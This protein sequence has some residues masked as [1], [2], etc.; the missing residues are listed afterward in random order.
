MDYNE[1]AEF[2]AM[3]ADEMEAMDD[4]QSQTAKPQSHTDK[5]Q[6][7]TKSHTPHNKE[8]C[9]PLKTGLK[10]QNEFTTGLSTNTTNATNATDGVSDNTQTDSVGP[11][12][13]FSFMRAP[14]Q[15][16]N[17]FNNK[18]K[19]IGTAITSTTEEV[20]FEEL[21]PEKEEQQS[22]RQRETGTHKVYSKA[23]SGASVR[24]VTERGKA[25][26]RMSH[27]TGSVVPASA[28]TQQLLSFPFSQIKAQ[29]MSSYNEKQ[30]EVAAAVERQREV[31]A[32]APADGQHQLWVNTYVPQNYIEL[33]S[34]DGVN[35]QVLNWMKLWDGLV[36]GRK[37]KEKAAPLIPKWAQNNP[38]ANW[39]PQYVE[40]EYDL[41]GY[42]YRKTILLCGPP[43][44]GKTT[45]A[46][47]IARH[48]GYNVVE[49]NAS[50]ERSA[51]QFTDVIENSTQMTSALD[52][53]GK[54]NCLII[55]EIDGAGGP[56]IKALFNILS[57]G[58]PKTEFGE[59]KKKAKDKRLKRPI[60]CICN[61]AW[62]P[63]LR[64]LR[65]I[66]MIVNFPVTQSARLAYRLK[67]ICNIEQ[68]TADMATLLYLCEK[69]DNDIRSSLNTLQFMK[70]KKEPLSMTQLKSMSIGTK[71]I[72]QGM[73]N[74]WANIFT[75]PKN[76]KALSHDKSSKHD[77][78][79]LYDILKLVYSTGDY[80]KQMEGIYE[81]FLTLKIKEA[82]F[83]KVA[84]CQDW[85][86][87]YDTLGQTI[88]HHMLFELYD[89]LTYVP[90]AFHFMFAGSFKP[91]ITN[92]SQSWQNF[93]AVQLTTEIVNVI[94]NECVPKCRL[95]MTSQY[96]ST[97][98]VS[99][100]VRMLCP[101]FRPVN[102][103]LY[104]I[105][106][107]RA[108]DVLASVMASY[109]LSFVQTKNQDG[110]VLFKLE[111]DILSLTSYTDIPEIKELS[112]SVKQM[113][114]KEV[115]LKRIGA[116]VTG[117]V[118]EK[119]KRAPTTSTTV[120]NNASAPIKK[121][122]FL[123]ETVPVDYMAKIVKNKDELIRKMEMFNIA[124]C[125]VLSLCLMKGV[126]NLHGQ[127][128]SFLWHVLCSSL[129]FVKFSEVS[130]TSQGLK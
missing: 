87:F 130:S 6:S 9:S 80:D 60:I 76:V 79:R 48:A 74:F 47:I 103:Q 18:R 25:Y 46:H 59:T 126:R 123:K 36:F 70:T 120:S 64:D 72:Q 56:A 99:Y 17:A 38:N 2:E 35:R 118:V 105:E 31:A 53:E 55:D 13:E 44:L 83:S 21:Y 28:H 127:V 115:E 54:P 109:D 11:V 50:D 92:P 22:K 119:V 3:Y 110:V 52:K 14:L 108:K 29:V 16:N 26:L 77:Q 8:N 84:D 75:L 82:N 113:L 88:K 73:F 68:L 95:G 94:R 96:I 19:S 39:V 93:Q 71:D 5:H 128:K 12:L 121:I 63:A 85:L 98:L 65:K 102:I 34:D 81:N 24:I 62:G 4:M 114:V 91:K 7:H 106:E 33:L 42:P 51:A 61:D 107:K 1:E 100:L 111:P 20:T 49:M 23:P 125:R 112:Y 116:G 43:G 122:D 15:I 78:R 117:E 67:S 101:S 58:P 57:A 30:R 90:I 104:S 66:A 40:P 124:D 86:I 41:A 69:T 45:L 27:T 37:M 129:C 89:Y 32:A 10:Q 97:E